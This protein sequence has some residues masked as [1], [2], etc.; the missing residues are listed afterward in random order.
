MGT[1]KTPK[2]KQEEAFN[3]EFSGKFVTRVPPKLHAELVKDAKKE[4]VS[5]NL[6]AACALA[7][8]VGHREGVVEGQRSSRAL[9]LKLVEI[10]ET[11]MLELAGRKK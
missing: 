3:K 4:G 1:K 11:Q 9:I 5:L 8:N 7:R 10:V 6:Y 2:A